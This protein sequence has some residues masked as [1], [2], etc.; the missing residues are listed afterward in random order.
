L[1]SVL[2]TWILDILPLH[3]TGYWILAL[4]CS[5]LDI[6]YSCIEQGGFAKTAF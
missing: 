5:L 4:G 2:F 1:A 6:G 3:G